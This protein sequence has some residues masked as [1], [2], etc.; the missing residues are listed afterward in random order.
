[1]TTELN[2]VSKI[3]ILPPNLKEEALSFINNLLMKEKKKV[4]KKKVPKAG[5]GTVKFVMADDFD[6]PLEDFKKYM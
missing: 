1:M 2:L 3:A 6:A 4:A 5:T